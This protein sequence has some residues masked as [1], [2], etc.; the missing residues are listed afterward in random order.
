M[1][2][3]FSPTKAASSVGGGVAFDDKDP[4]HS[5]LFGFF[6]I[7]I[8]ERAFF[9]QNGVSPSRGS[10]NFARENG[11]DIRSDTINLHIRRPVLFQPIDWAKIWPFLGSTKLSHD[12]CEKRGNTY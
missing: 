2:C 7:A 10:P 6:G 3:L 11:G 5:L 9:L 8:L 4:D 12:H 1:N